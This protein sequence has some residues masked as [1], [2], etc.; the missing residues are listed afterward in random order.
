MKI[1]TLCGS[2]RF[3]REFEVIN[4]QLTLE[5]NVVL[6]VAFFPGADKVEISDEQKVL[7]DQIH[8]MKIDLS[9]GIFVLNVDGYTGE[10]TRSEIAYAESNG[11]FVKY[12]SDFPDLV[13]LCDYATMSLDNLKS[14]ARVN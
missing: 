2:T 8:K 3:K 14:S 13:T 12:L 7:V 6:S 1:I 10:S 9:D 4:R 11:K 5:G